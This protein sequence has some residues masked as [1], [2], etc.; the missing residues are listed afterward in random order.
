MSHFGDTFYEFLKTTLKC[1]KLT[2]ELAQ[3]GI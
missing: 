2:H 3:N 1:Y